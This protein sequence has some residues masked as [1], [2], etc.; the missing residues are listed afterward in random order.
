M[1]NLQDSQD[2]DLDAILGELC[3][4][5]TQVDREIGQA[6]DSKRLSGA[7]D[8]FL[9]RDE[10][11]TVVGGGTRGGDFRSQTKRWPSTFPGPTA[12]PPRRAP[13]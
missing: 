11:E 9:P 5:E 2:V 10:R 8:F 7:S 6:R 1:A 12:G 4:L 3:A 13:D